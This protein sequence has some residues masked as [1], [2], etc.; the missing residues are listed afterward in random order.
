MNGAMQFEQSK[1]LTV[2]ILGIMILLMTVF[3]VWS[4]T[5]STSQLIAMPTIGILL[6]SY[7]ISYEIKADFENRKHFKLFGTTV[8]IQRLE[9]L[10]P[11]YISV[12]SARF[13]QGV[14]MGPVAAIGRINRDDAFVIRM[15]KG[16]RYFTVFK[17][18]NLELATRRADVL[19]ALLNV[20]VKK[21]VIP[22]HVEHK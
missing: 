14:D 1:P 16:N 13:K 18:N 3:I 10:F 8:F 2:K 21:K 9:L 6:L 20:E 17:T 22:F 12:F 19:G 7:S 15:F 4:N 5:P 11:D